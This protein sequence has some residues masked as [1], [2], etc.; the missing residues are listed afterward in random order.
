MGYQIYSY[1]RYG[2]C[3]LRHVPHKSGS[4][5]G[6]MAIKTIIPC[7]PVPIGSQKIF[8]KHSLVSFFMGITNLLDALLSLQV[9]CEQNGCTTKLH[10]QHF[11]EDPMKVK[12]YSES[13]VLSHFSWESR[14][15]RT[16]IF[17]FQWFACEIGK[18]RSNPTLSAARTFY[19]TCAYFTHITQHRKL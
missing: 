12:K 11:S 18:N 6:S 1:Q 17:R 8:W 19:F 5:F 7:L 2:E 4:C 16:L 14:N 15:H 3:V 9:I 10:T 13:T